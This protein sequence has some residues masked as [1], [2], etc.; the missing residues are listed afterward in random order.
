M[1]RA[2]AEIVSRDLLTLANSNIYFPQKNKH[3]IKKTVAPTLRI[4]ELSGVKY[5]IE[6]LSELKIKLW[7]ILFAQP[8]GP[9]VAFWQQ[10][11]AYPQMAGINGPP[12]G[13]RTSV[14]NGVARQQQG[15]FSL[16]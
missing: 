4:G 1:A 6:P 7:K 13:S 2:R 8:A 9:V 16:V 3:G 5:L 14:E 11:V 12:T 10:I 15:N